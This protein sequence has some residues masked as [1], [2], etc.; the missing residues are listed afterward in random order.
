MADCQ[1]VVFRVRADVEVHYR[2][3][4]YSRRKTAERNQDKHDAMRPPSLD[5]FLLFD[6]CR[7]SM[8][9]HMHTQFEKMSK[10]LAIN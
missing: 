6:P 4:R 3:D 9:S 1:T 10:C 8:R 7:F 5:A 2:A